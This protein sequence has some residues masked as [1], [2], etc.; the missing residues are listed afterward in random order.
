MLEDEQKL[1]MM[2]LINLSF[3][4]ILV[5]IWFPFPTS[6]MFNLHERG[7]DLSSS[8]HVMLCK[9]FF[10]FSRVLTKKKRKSLILIEKKATGMYFENEKSSYEVSRAR[11]TSLKAQKAYMVGHAQW[12]NRTEI[13]QWRPVFLKLH[14]SSARPYVLPLCRLHT[15]PSIKAR[16]CIFPVFVLFKQI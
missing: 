2:E 4:L 3:D 10:L 11:N 13:V 6:F 12:Q 14:T 9:W 5:P 8:I 7:S 16:Q 1:G 15:Y